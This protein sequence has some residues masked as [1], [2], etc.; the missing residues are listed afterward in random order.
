VRSKLP[1]SNQHATETGAGA[2]SVT[3]YDLDKLDISEND[4]SFAK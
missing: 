4:S 2:V 1:W 3:A